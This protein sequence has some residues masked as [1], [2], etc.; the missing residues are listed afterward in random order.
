[1]AEWNA[2]DD[3]IVTL[4]RAGRARIQA[5]SGAALRDTTGRT[6]SSAN[7]NIESLVL[8]AVELVVGQ[9]IASGAAGIEA[10]VVCS[11]ADAPIQH[12]DLA[13]IR[14]FGGSGIPVHHVGMTGDV[15]ATQLT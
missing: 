2:E 7:V 8:S 10:V 4:A 5:T 1:M 12:H 11:D 6:Y 14:G 15:L 9:A 13:V 3:K